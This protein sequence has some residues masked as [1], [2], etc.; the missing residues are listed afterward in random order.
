MLV[1]PA[2]EAGVV[3]HGSQILAIKAKASQDPGAD[4][5]KLV[6]GKLT[7]LLVQI[8]FMVVASGKALTRAHSSKSV[9]AS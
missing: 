3:K 5:L 6:K 2:V 8:L 4:S 7:S 1:H 9:G